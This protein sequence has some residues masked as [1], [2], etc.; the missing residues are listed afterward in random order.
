MLDGRRNLRFADLLRLA[1]AFG[2]ELRRQ[3]GSHHILLHPAV[4]EALN[5]Q[6]D[7]GGQAK[8]YQVRQL[9]DLVETHGLTLGD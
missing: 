3:R 4:P 6:P 9:V 8:P 1:E 5:L 2:F 7:K